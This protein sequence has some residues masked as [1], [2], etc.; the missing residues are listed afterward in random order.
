VSEK[1]ALATY[2][3]NHGFQFKKQTACVIVDFIDNDWES[4]LKRLKK[5]VRKEIRRKLKKATTNF[6][7]QLVA[8]TSWDE[9]K[10]NFHEM[11]EIYRKRWANDYRPM[12]S[13][14]E[15]TCWENAVKAQFSCKKMIYFRLLFDGKPAAYRL[16]FIHKNTY[17]DWN[18]SFDPNLS[19]FSPG[20]VLFALMIKHLL[21]KD[22]SRINFMAGEYDWK[23]DWSPNRITEANFMLTSCPKSVIISAL[24][25]Y[26]YT[27]RDLL[28]AYY[29]K[30]LKLSLF[31]FLSR[32]FLSFYKQ[33]AGQKI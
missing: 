9:C 13:T 27:L 2:L 31:R 29:H 11:E 10:L 32:N 26:H 16:G 3:I 24:R 8:M 14:I 25:W 15:T 1:D 12:K 5:N 20:V 23:L 19:D 6:D 30:T 17:Y 4:Y 7:I 33:F 18:T 22:I 28:K 21:Q